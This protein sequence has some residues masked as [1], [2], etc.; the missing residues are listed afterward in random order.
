MVGLLQVFKRS[1]LLFWQWDL[2]SFQSLEC[3]D[4][5][6]NRWDSIFGCEWPQRYVF[7]SLE[8]SEAPIIQKNKSENVF[9]GLIDFDGS[10]QLIDTASKESTYFHFKVESFA[11]AERGLGGIFGFDLASGSVKLCST[12]NNW[13]RSTMVSYRYMEPILVKSILWAPDDWSDVESMSSWWVKICVVAYLD[14][15]M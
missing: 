7:P 4:P 8:I 9:P 2:A 14:W 3:D 11:L 12:Y 10:T 15:K 5:R 6:G 13:W 1:W